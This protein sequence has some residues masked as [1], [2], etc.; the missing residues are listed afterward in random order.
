MTGILQTCS[1]CYYILERIDRV[2]VVWV[3]CEQ[4]WTSGSVTHGAA[5]G[6][7]K[8]YVEFWIMLS[9]STWSLPCLV[10]WAKPRLPQSTICTYYTSV[11]LSAV[12]CTARHGDAKWCGYIPR[13]SHSECDVGSKFSGREWEG[14]KDVVCTF[15]RRHIWTYF[16]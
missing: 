12:P 4:V 16:R 15:V 7:N 13:R 14:D 2:W 3:D 8:F 6:V 9:K 10:S 11:L 5:C 1:R